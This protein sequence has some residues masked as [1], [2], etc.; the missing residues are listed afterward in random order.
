MTFVYGV[1]QG[2]AEKIY[3]PRTA[4]AVIANEHGV[5]SVVAAKYRDDLTWQGYDIVEYLTGYLDGGMPA[6]TGEAI[7]AVWAEAV[8]T[9]GAWVFADGVDA[10]TQAAFLEEQE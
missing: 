7:A 5:C 3:D 10:E 2:R 6:A 8:R 4:A 1:V 9:P